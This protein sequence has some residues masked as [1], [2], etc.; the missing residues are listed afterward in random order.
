MR[1]SAITCSL[2]FSNASNGGAPLLRSGRGVG[3]GRPVG[4][5]RSTGAGSD[6]VRPEAG[7]TQNPFD[8]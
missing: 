1:K 6:G 7:E 3:T 2:R 8:F 5:V 4:M